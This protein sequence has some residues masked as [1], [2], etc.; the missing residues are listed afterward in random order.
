MWGLANAPEQATVK[1]AKQFNL[2]FAA[3]TRNI[4][5]VQL[6]NFSLYNSKCHKHISSI[7]IFF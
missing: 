3:A 4:G 7:Q 5:I 6:F 1:E 2:N